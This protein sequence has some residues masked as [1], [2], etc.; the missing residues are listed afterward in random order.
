MMLTRGRS[1]SRVKN[2]SFGKSKMA[3]VTIRSCFSP[4]NASFFCVMVLFTS[5]EVT[6]FILEVFSRPS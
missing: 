1:P 5:K 4:F 3:A 6:H 2:V